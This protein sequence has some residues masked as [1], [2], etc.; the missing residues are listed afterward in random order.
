MPLQ[1]TRKIRIILGL[2]L[3]LLV[4]YAALGFW[5]VPHLVRSQVEEFGAQ[6]WQR[7][8]TLGEISFNPFTLALEVGKFSFQDSTGAPMLAFDRLYVNLDISS[9]W[10][11]GISF[12]EIELDQPVGRA[13][14]C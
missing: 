10:R 6:H 13:V 12:R 5:L 1:V 8:P 2:L 4:A 9:L 7:K 11:L 3:L 14:V